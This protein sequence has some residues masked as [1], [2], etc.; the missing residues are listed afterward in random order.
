MRGTNQGQSAAESELLINVT[1]AVCPKTL[2]GATVAFVN[3]LIAE[4]AKKFPRE[5]EPPLSVAAVPI[6]QKIL[7]AS[8]GGPP[9]TIAFALSMIVSAVLI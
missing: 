2:P 7:Q 1:P 8:D 4:L 5:C 6:V 3:M 9:I